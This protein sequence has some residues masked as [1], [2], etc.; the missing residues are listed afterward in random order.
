M[1]FL[2]TLL[3]VLMLW[4]IR[5][6][7]GITGMR[8]LGTT[9]DATE[10]FFALVV[11]IL[12]QVALIVIPGMQG[13][14]D[15]DWKWRNL[16]LFGISFLLVPLIF[17]GLVCWGAVPIPTYNPSCT[18]AGFVMQALYPGFLSFLINYVG[19]DTYRRVK[20]R[21]FS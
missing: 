2:M 7:A 15:T 1:R 11:R 3:V 10:A 20:A 8:A 21:D 17:Y 9:A 14:W 18:F 12:V 4:A 16:I 19:E 13:L 6:V 5:L